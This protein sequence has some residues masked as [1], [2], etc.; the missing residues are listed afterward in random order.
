MP[1]PD[2]PGATPMTYSTIH[3]VL[4]LKLSYQ[5]AGVEKSLG[6]NWEVWHLELLHPHHTV[7]GIEISL[8]EN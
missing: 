1:P 8:G 6:E 3:L 2:P 4:K 7:A 5:L